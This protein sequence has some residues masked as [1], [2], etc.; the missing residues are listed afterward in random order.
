MKDRQFNIALSQLVERLN[1]SWTDELFKSEI[2]LILKTASELPW[3]EEQA[4][5]VAEKTYGDVDFDVL[6]FILRA[7]KGVSSD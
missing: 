4:P 5:K 1:F 2:E 3:R 7:A 6:G